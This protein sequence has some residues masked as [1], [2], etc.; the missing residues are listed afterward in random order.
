MGIQGLIPLLEKSW[1]TVNVSEFSGCTVAIDA[2]CWLHKGVYTC[3]EKLARGEDSQAYVYYCMRFVS[4]LLAQNIKPILVFDGQHLPAK[5]D[6][7]SK[8]RKLREQNRKKAAELMRLD[9]GKEASSLLR[10]SIDVTHKMALNLIKRCREINV[11]CIVAPYEA[12]SQL[13][14]LNLSGIAHIVITEDSDLLLFGCKRVLFKMDQNGAGIL[15][16]Q[17][18]LH[19]SMNIQPEKFSLEKF[20]YMCILSGCDYLPS[21]SGVGLMKARQFITRT[22]EPDIYKALSRLGSFMN[23]KIPPEYR[24]QFMDADRMF[25]YQPVFDPLSRRIIPLN[26]VSDPSLP[27]LVSKLTSDQAYQLALGNI[28]PFSLEIMDDW[29]PDIQLTPDKIAKKKIIK[30][31]HKSIWS[32][33][34]QPLKYNPEVCTLTQGIIK[35]TPTISPKVSISTNR[36]SPIRQTPVVK[37]RLP[38]TEDDILNTLDEIYENEKVSEKCDIAEEKHKSTK[39]TYIK[40]CKVTDE[41]FKSELDTDEN[42]SPSFLKQLTKRKYTVIDPDVQIVSGYFSQTPK[43]SEV[44]EEESINPFKCRKITINKNKNTNDNLNTSLNSSNIIEENIQLQCP[45]NK[46]VLEEE[47]INPFKSRKITINKNKNTNDD[48]NTSLNSSNI[49][50][51]NLQQLQCLENKEIDTKTFNKKL[52]SQTLSAFSWKSYS[53][54]RMVTNKEKPSEEQKY[55]NNSNYF[56]SVDKDIKKDDLENDIDEGFGSQST[57]GTN[58]SPVVTPKQNKRSYPRTGLSKSTGKKSQTLLSKFGFKTGDKL[59]R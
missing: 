39:S 41:L 44:L 11:D 35:S 22:S 10:R 59:K 48:L 55:Q 32:K 2:Y 16:E 19:L 25:Q 24:D 13:A 42:E 54:N 49:I 3:A 9:K 8:R 20:R 34:Y 6:T 53:N 51:E 17:E 38:V 26:D 15:I 18:K 50:E 23:I 33:D 47:S 1:R 46:E 28:D 31:C 14:Y 58:S 40:D 52:P 43:I 7:E 36:S 4:M 45:E 21:I 37:K 29:D 56:T 27:V 57:K 5:A 30:A 12:D